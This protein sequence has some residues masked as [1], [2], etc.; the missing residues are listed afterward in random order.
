[1][2]PTH[3][4]VIDVFAGPGGLGEGFSR[5]K[6]AGAGFDIKLSIE[7]EPVAH[8]TLL[9]RSFFRKFSDRTPPDEYYQYVRGEISKDDLFAR[10]PKEAEEASEEAWCAEL[11]KTP[12]EEVHSRITG[13]LNGAENWLLIGG[14]PCQAYSMVGRSRILGK[15]REKFSMELGPLF[16]EQNGHLN[17]EELARVST[18][19]TNS[20]ARDQFYE[21][22]RHKLYKEYL[23]IV[24]VHQPS[25]FV[26]ENVKGILS[27]KVKTQNVLE[28]ILRDLRSPWH[29]LDADRRDGLMKP[30]KVFDYKIQSFVVETV[31]GIEPSWRDFVINSEDFGIPQ[32][33]HRVILLGIRNDI[34]AKPRSLKRA[35]RLVSVKE[36]IGNLPKV[37]SHISR[38]PDNSSEW[39]DAIR[40][41]IEQVLHP[42]VENEYVRSNITHAQKSLAIDSGVGG[43]YLEGDYSLTGALGSWLADKKVGGILQHRARSHMVSD[44]IRYMFA[45]SYAQHTGVSPTLYE[46]PSVLL[47]NHKNTKDLA[48]GSGRKER[49]V[50]F[51]DRFRVQT[52]DKPASTITSHISKDGHY[53]IHYDPAQCRS[54]TGREAAR[55]QTFPDNYFFEGNRTEQY[56]QIGNAVPPYLAYQ[57]ADVVADLFMRTSLNAARK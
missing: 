27:S 39:A 6:H 35:D 26:M 52:A 50:I 8:K 34:T 28:N 9:L 33:R 32:K 2:P 3:I 53:Y 49:S 22:H 18:E 42:H 14:P 24:A 17:S 48:I 31:D 47:P 1:M 20:R 10:Y 19:A 43:Q 12:R 46:F 36:V 21:D 45:A 56:H 16:Q 54:L 13:A 41:G 55:L 5:Y 44:L 30:E 40:T 51:E 38:R 57:L 15:L 4:P 11:G 23:E 29:A 25:I 37:R 7:K